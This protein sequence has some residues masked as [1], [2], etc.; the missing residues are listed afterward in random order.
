MADFSSAH[1]LV[2]RAEGGYQR[3]PRDPGN[4]TG[5]RVN[6]GA[7]V[8]TRYGIAAPTLRAWRRAEITAAD[9]ET[10]PEAE[11]VAI[12]RRHYW[13]AL[14][15]EALPDQPLADLLYDGAVN[16]GVEAMRRALLAAF[17]HLGVT[18][19]GSAA[20]DLVRR[21]ALLPPA[22]VHELV[23][24]YRRDRYPKNSPFTAGW[25]KRLDRLRRPPEAPAA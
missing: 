20:P 16:Q 8:G 5:G 18:G 19:H 24:Q 2:A 3:D 14:G 21:A 6:R 15:L 1:R 4:W 7:L 22:A 17:Q 10:L 23:W 12:F 9:M 13:D 25:L 11:A